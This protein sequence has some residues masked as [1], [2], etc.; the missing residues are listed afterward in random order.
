MQKTFLQ[1][2]ER[3]FRKY[4][5]DELGSAY[6]S[7][8]EKVLDGDHIELLEIPTNRYGGCEE[9]ESDRVVVSSIE[10]KRCFEDYWS[11]Y[12]VQERM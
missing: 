10:N 4:A 9:I 12:C 2:G 3:F 7:Y 5:T 1:A 8:L 6:N 11:A